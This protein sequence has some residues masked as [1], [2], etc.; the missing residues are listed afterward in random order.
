M[1]SASTKKNRSEVVIVGLLFGAASTVLGAAWGT[2]VSACVLWAYLGKKETKFSQGDIVRLAAA[3]L[4]AVMVCNV[5]MNL[6]AFKEGLIAGWN[7]G[8][9]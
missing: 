8:P 3:W 6:G 9:Y 1:T 5:L 2:F 7:A 4:L